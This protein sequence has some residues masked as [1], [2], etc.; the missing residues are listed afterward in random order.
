MYLKNLNSLKKSLPSRN[1]E[2]RHY[3]KHIQQYSVL[4]NRAHLYMID[5]QG[6]GQGQKPID[7]RSARESITSSA[8]IS[9]MD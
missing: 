6:K 1:V 3:E 8:S 7:S 9:M 4:S 5:Y 2:N